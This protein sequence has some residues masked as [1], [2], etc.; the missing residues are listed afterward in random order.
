M[1]S[2]A[3]V[4]LIHLQAYKL[5]PD[6]LKTVI[7]QPG[8]L[9]TSNNSRR[10]THATDA[11]NVA[12][13]TDIV[14]IGYHRQEQLVHLKAIITTED[15]HHTPNTPEINVMTGEATAD[16]M[17]GL[18]Q[19]TEVQAARDTPAQTYTPAGTETLDEGTH[20]SATELKANH[21]TGSNQVAIDH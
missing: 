21:P 11:T 6:T 19:E 15:D 16:L 9:E 8:E 17:L 10:F 4:S 14:G 1:D 13:F 7:T 12:T 2:G 18:I 3:A 20:Q 5:M